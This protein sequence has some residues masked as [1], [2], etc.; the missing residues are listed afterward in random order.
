MK[1]LD[2]L[3]MKSPD[4]EIIRETGPIPTRRIVLSLAGLILGIFFSFLITGINGIKASPTQKAV[5]EIGK[6]QEVTQ[7]GTD[8]SDKIK[9]SFP[10]SKE[11]LSIGL[12]TFVICMITYQGLYSSLKLYN[13]EPT[14]LVLF[15]SFQYGFFWQ[16]VVKGGAAL[17]S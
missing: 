3:L 14:F 4:S 13:N 11:L 2:Y 16:S 1:I 12:I 15:V 10:E 6:S 8:K 7:S 17:L 9:I 5:S